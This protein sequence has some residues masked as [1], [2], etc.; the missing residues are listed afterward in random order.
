MRRPDL[1]LLVSALVLSAAVALPT[2]RVETE[3]ADY[4]EQ[5][6]ELLSEVED[7]DEQMGGIDKVIH[8]RAARSDSSSLEALKAGAEEK[9]TNNADSSGESSSSEEDQIDGSQATES[10]ARRRRS[11]ERYRNLTLLATICPKADTSHLEKGSTLDSRIEIK[12][13]Y[14]LCASLQDW[15]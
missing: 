3:E 4:S 9:V 11:D 2:S 8:R 12:D 14:E 10:S 1:L 13:F 6:L 5:Q 7:S 15:K